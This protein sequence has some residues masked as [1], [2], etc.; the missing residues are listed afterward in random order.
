MIGLLV[1]MLV[2]WCSVAEAAPALEIVRRLCDADVRLHLGPGNCML[3]KISLICCPCCLLLFLVA[4]SGTPPD[5]FAGL[6]VFC[7]IPVGMFV[8]VLLRGRRAAV[9][10]ESLLPCTVLFG[11]RLLLIP[12][13]AS[14]CVL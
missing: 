2:R 1:V 8:D 12:G 9:C 5:R 7:H 10:L 6:L 4:A 13:L 3:E 14:R 11:R